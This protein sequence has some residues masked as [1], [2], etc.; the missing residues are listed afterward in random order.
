MPRPNS[1]TGKYTSQSHKNSFS[2]VTSGCWNYSV[3]SIAVVEKGKG[4]EQCEGS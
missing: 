1:Y 3:D 4:P 2:E